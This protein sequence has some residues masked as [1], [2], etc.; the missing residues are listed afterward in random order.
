M[1]HRASAVF[2][3]GGVAFWTITNTICNV[4]F[5]EFVSFVLLTRFTL[6]PIGL[7]LEAL[8]L[9]AI[10][11]GDFRLIRAEARF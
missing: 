1:H 8:I 10:L 4:E 2:L 9:F 7:A 5:V 11:A 3:D 6:V